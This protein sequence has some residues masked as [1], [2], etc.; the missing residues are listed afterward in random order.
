MGRELGQ[1]GLGVVDNDTRGTF[2]LGRMRIGF[3]GYI[4][5]QVPLDADD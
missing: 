4:S 2:P 1:A 3:V 5:M